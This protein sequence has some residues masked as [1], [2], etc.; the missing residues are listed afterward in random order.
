MK[1]KFLFV[2]VLGLI[3]TAFVHLTFDNENL[4]TKKITPI[5]SPEEEKTLVLPTLNIPETTPFD[6]DGFGNAYK[7]GYEKG[8]YAF[9]I[10]NGEEPEKI[11][12]YTVG[13]EDL[14]KQQEAEEYQ[15]AVE[16]GYVDGYHK[17]CNTMNC[18][19]SSIY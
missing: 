18:P 7:M 16:K 9:L 17:A 11:T 3:F 1:F 12:S 8:Y 5:K 2:F 6:G 10:Q 13:V 15:N 4:K 14:Y 19:R